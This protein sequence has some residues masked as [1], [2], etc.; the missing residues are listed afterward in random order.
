MPKCISKDEALDFIKDSSKF[1][2]SVR[3]ANMMKNLASH[4]NE[5]QEEWELVGLLHDLDYDHTIGSRQLHGIIAGE[6]LQGKI[7]S[8]SIE[9]IKS[10]DYRTRLKPN[11]RLA[12]IL[13]ACDA[14]D[15]LIELMIQKKMNITKLMIFQLLD[16]WTIEKPWLKELIKNVENDN[17]TLDLFLDYCLLVVKDK[18]KKLKYKK[19]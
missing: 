13:I 19:Q 2:H 11:N 15:A 5:N 18:N 17:I 6:M 8:L 4:F 12:R 14:F 16:T 3:V 7:S 9:A 10:H 1:S